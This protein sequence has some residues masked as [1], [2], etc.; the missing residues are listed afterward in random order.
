M[1]QR[2][3]AQRHRVSCEQS[4]E[5]AIAC[6]S[7]IHFAILSLSDEICSSSLGPREPGGREEQ[8]DH[9]VCWDGDIYSR[10]SRKYRSGVLLRHEAV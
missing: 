4:A 9:R 6:F 7:I 5:D 1:S 3:G 2:G 10:Y 8:P